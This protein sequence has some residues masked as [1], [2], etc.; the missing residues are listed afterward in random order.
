MLEHVITE[1]PNPASAGI[2]RLSTIRMLEIINDEDETIPHAVRAELR[3]IAEAVDLIADCL[4]HGGRLFFLGAGTSGRLGVLE[5]VEC[6]PTFNIPV[7][8]VQAIVAG[9]EAALFHASD[10]IEDDVESGIR[11]LESRGFTPR[12]VLVGISASGESAYVVAAVE[13][14]TQM[15]AR[16][17]G[18]CCTRTSALARAATV[19]ITPETGPEIIAGSTRLKAATATKLVLNMLTTASMIRLGHV[20]DNLMVNVQ[21]TNRK[22]RER[23]RR[24]ISQV[25]GAD[26]AKACELLTASG[27]CVKTAIVMERLDVP[28]E[29]A[30]RRLSACG[31]SIF[32]AIS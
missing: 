27:D 20:F 16:T 4:G 11:D 23:A 7:A 32:E 5:A 14:A 17:V 2:D 13:R 18:I 6:P 12:D 10:Y 1:R 19:P 15:G 22:L 24:I 9:G 21:P 8:Q 3:H 28:K 31:G 30:E 26:E 29:E 25:T